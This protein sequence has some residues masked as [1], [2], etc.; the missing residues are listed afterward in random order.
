[1]Y[2]NFKVANYSRALLSPE[3]FARHISRMFS[4]DIVNGFLVTPGTG[5]QIVVSDGN[6]IINYGSSGSTSARLVSLVASFTAPVTVADASNPRIDSVVVYVDNSVTL[7]SGTP[8]SANLDGKG[9]AKLAVV[10]G[11]PAASPVSPTEAMI[12][13][14]IGAGNPWTR[15]ATVR[16]NAGVTVIA[17]GQIT[18]TR[19][20]LKLAV[21]VP[22]ASVEIGKTTD[23][24]GWVVASVGG[25]REWTKRYAV[26]P[27]SVN[28]VT[29]SLLLD[30]V[31]LPTGITNLSGVITS[32]NVIHTIESGTFSWGMEG[33]PSSTGLTVRIR[34]SSNNALNPGVVTIDVMLKEI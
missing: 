18:G 29:R 25:R 3:L 19:P 4:G 14:A 20:M 1:M 28:G 15:I 17:A 13:A 8:S 22:E 26:S 2:D 9:V 6:A 7:P 31:A 30:N 23:A 12:L 5:M 33:G 27:R 34:N 10:R 11:N 24:N 16:V 32:L 21:P